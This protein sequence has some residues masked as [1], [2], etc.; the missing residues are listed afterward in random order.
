MI[1]QALKNKEKY[2]TAKFPDKENFD[3][4][5]ERKILEE[6]IKDNEMITRTK[7]EKTNLTKKINATAEIIKSE[8]AKEKLQKLVNEINANLK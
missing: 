6:E 1:I 7:T 3:I 8:N 4:I 5:I 2:E